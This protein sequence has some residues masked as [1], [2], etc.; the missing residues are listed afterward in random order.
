MGS[1]AKG[2]V[3]KNLTL[4]D[5]GHCNPAK[6]ICDQSVVPMNVSP[7]PITHRR[8]VLVLYAMKLIS[9]TSTIQKEYVI[10]Y[11]SISNS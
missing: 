7:N 10:G 9:G 11:I 3:S 5:G 6:T 8:C 2:L 4:L 1:R